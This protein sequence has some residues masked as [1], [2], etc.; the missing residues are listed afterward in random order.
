MIDNAVKGKNISLY[1][2]GSVRRTFTHI[3]DV[4]D[5]LISGAFSDKCVNDVYNIGGEDMSLWEVA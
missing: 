2:N 1:G 4:C 3:E 5:N